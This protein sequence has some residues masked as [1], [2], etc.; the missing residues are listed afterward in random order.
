[1]KKIFFLPLLAGTTAILTGCRRNKEINVVTYN[2]D[3]VN[4]T[5]KC[6]TSEKQIRDAINPENYTPDEAKSLYTI[7]VETCTTSLTDAKKMKAYKDDASLKNAVIALLETELTYLEK[8]QETFPYREYAELTDDQKT[9]YTTLETE[10]LRI[11]TATQ[12]A[13]E[14][15]VS[16][17]KAFSAKHGYALQKEAEEFLEIGTGELPSETPTPITPEQL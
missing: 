6:F 13:S 2:D 8:F 10:L 15:L 3:F 9:V 4:L 7:A 12:T 16:I 5:E 14:N 17:Q 1:M 11:G